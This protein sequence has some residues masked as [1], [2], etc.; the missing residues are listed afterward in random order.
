MFIASDEVFM[1]TGKIQ[2]KGNVCILIIDISYA[3]NIEKGNITLMVQGVG[4][5]CLRLELFLKTLAQV[6]GFHI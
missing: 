5:A 4:Y 1:G 3:L 2:G 6:L